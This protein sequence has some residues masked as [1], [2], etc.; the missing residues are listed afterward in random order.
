MEEH[1]DVHRPHRQPT[2]RGDGCLYCAERIHHGQLR[3]RPPG[4]F[5]EAYA[6]T[7]A[8]GEMAMTQACCPELMTV[9]DAPHQV[10]GPRDNLFLPN[11][12]ETAGTGRL[13]VFGAGRNRICFTHVDNYAH[14][15]LLRWSAEDLERS[16]RRLRD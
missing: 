16:S 9:A 1:L 10:Y 4:A 13:R 3:I 8:M 6:E 11:L 7:K 2:L 12:L 15:E 14:T 5:L